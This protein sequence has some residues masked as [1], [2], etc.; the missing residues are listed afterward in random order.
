MTSRVLR[1]RRDRPELFTAY[2][3]LA[4]V[5]VTAVDGTSAGAVPTGVAVDP[6]GDVFACGLVLGEL[7]VGE[8]MV[9]DR[10]LLNGNILSQA[11]PSADIQGIPF[12]YTTSEQVTSLTDG[13][14]G[15]ANEARCQRRPR[16]RG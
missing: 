15:F 12:A 14:L 7:L 3:P 1:L 4:Q 13:A 11:H 5:S 16:W 8:P 9:G 2:R 6:A 10:V